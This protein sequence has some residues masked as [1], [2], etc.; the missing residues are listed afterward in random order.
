MS[1]PVG[2]AHVLYLSA[3]DSLAMLL[4][5]VIFINVN[6]AIVNLLPIPALDGGHIVFAIVEAIRGKPLPQKFLATSQLVFMALLLSLMAYITLHDI[7]REIDM[8]HAQKEISKAGNT[9]DPVFKNQPQTP[10]K[11]AGPAPSAPSK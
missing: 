11:D 5:L 10:A 8:A 2:I 3:R 6:L 4:F 1:G 9:P 7:G